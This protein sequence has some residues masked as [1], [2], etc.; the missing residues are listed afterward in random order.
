MLVLQSIIDLKIII[1]VGAF[2]QNWYQIQRND[3]DH[4]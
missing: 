2:T 1:V 3:A 4:I